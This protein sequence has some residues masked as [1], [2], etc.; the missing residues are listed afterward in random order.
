MTS[1]L[2]QQHLCK[3]DDNQEQTLTSPKSTLACGTPAARVR[4]LARGQRVWHRSLAVI[5]HGKMGDMTRAVPGGQAFSEE[6]LRPVGELLQAAAQHGLGVAFEPDREGWRISYLIDDWPAYQDYELK[7]GTLANA[8]DLEVGAKAAL[9]PLIQL[10][11]R[12]ERYFADGDG[13]SR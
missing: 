10:G 8:Y 5:Q 2:T 6:A 11:E 9:K 4:R 13:G 7:G 1:P 12:A 3:P